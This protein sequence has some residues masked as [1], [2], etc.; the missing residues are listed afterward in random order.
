MLSLMIVDDSNII[1]RK[2]ER[3]NDS[4]QFN[5]VASAANG[6]QALELFKQTRPQL[7]TMDLTMPEMDGI[8]CI[9]QLI[10]LDPA[11][12]ILV[13][14]ALSDKATGIDALKKGARGFLCK[15]FTEEQLLDALNEL[16]L[17]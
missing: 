11:V 1:R 10:A 6:L 9:Q 8:A 13:V 4:D 17:D 7:V 5:V 2:I 16:T 3:C 15:P 12:R 14:S